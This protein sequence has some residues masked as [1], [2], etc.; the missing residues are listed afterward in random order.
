M[1]LTDLMEQMHHLAAILQI[2]Q[3]GQ[4]GGAA[5]ADVLL[6][7]VVPEG[8]LTA[9]WARRYTD[10]PSADTFGACNGDLEKEIYTEGIYVG[11]SLL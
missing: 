5:V 11:C 1:E 4:Q 7:K 2:S 3:L 9:T 8:K 10:Y 6:G